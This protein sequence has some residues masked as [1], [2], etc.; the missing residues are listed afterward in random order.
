[1]I[2][3]DESEV[4]ALYLSVNDIRELQA[5]VPEIRH[6]TYK[7]NNALRYTLITN[8]GEVDGRF[9]N[10]VVGTQ[11][12]RLGPVLA[13]SKSTAFDLSP[14]FRLIKLT[15]KL[16]G[17]APLLSHLDGRVDGDEKPIPEA[18]LMPINLMSAPSISL[19]CLAEKGKGWNGPWGEVPAVL[20]RLL[21]G[22]QSDATNYLRM[23]KSPAKVALFNKMALVDAILDD[24]FSL[25]HL[26]DFNRVRSEK[27][28]AKPSISALRSKDATFGFHDHL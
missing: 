21:D 27:A 28:T 15:D 17:H 25:T 11:S 5:F 2:N 13:V 8:H 26:E 12:I 4:R 10:W 19:Q 9:A 24:V 16:P 23:G 20:I 7:N 3:L 6:F 18:L 14:R 22:Q 1:M